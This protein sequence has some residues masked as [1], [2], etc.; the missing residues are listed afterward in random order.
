MI[1]L[2][3]PTIVLR[4]L[5][6]ERTAR[7]PSSFSSRRER[8]CASSRS[9][10]CPSFSPTSSIDMPST[11]RSVKAAR[12]RA[13]SSPSASFTRSEICVLAATRSGVGCA[14]APRS[15]SGPCSRSAGSWAS[16]RWRRAANQVDRTVHGDPVQPGA[17]VRPGL[18]PAQLLVRLEPRLLHHVFRVLRIAGHPVRQREDV[19]GM[20]IRPAPETRRGRLRG[21]W[22]QPTRRVHPSLSLRRTCRGFG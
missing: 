3:R 10:S 4:V 7:A 18:E 15:L 5:L 17:K 16:S 6:P 22:R 14:S 2:R 11:C 8:C 1:V 13:V 20:A 9:S 19:A 12:S 21:P